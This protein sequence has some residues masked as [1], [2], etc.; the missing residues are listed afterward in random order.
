MLGPDTGP[1]EDMTRQPSSPDPQLSGT[2]R[3]TSAAPQPKRR[4]PPSPSGACQAILFAAT[5]RAVK[6]SPPGGLPP[7][8]TALPGDAHQRR[9]LRRAIAVGAVRP[10]AKPIASSTRRSL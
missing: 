6:A 1:G 5:D 8:L 2:W 10:Q 3:R 4:W 9:P 7:A